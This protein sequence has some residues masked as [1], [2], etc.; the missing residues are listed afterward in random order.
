MS[1]T[2]I[3]IADDH[4][5][6]REGL[7]GLILAHG[8][9]RQ[10]C[11]TVADAET[12]I[13]TAIEL[14]PDI[15]I[16][17]YKMGTIDGLVA[18]EQLKELVPDAEVLIFSGA[19]APCSLLEIYRSSVCGFMLKSEAVEELV[20]ALEALRYHHRF[21]SRQVTELYQRIIQ[22]AATNESLSAREI[23]TLRMIADG[24]SGKE[25]A[26]QMGISIKTVDTHRT[27]LLRKLHCNSAVDLT[28][29]ALRNGIVAL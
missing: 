14:K 15:V 6:V 24:K 8:A 7:P 12:A 1:P 22:T 4:A 2:R 28:R 17:D 19:V 10:I 11:G 23:E 27:H 29:Y 3:L 25:I 26:A 18:A 21:R 9:G 5:V 20:A 16:M 13:A